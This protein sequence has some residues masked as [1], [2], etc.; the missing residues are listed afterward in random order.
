MFK[1]YVYKNVNNRPVN[2]GG[3]QF[4]EGQELESDILI[5]GFNEAVTNGFLELAERKP[6]GA[7]PDATQASQTGDTGKVKVIWHMLFAIDG[8]EVLREAEVDPG[9]LVY[10][11]GN[12]LSDGK[13][14]KGWFKDAELTK[15]VNIDKV[16]APKEGEIHLWQIRGYRKRRNPSWKSESE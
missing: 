11:P 12:E 9:V 6:E 14:T 8:T 2:I 7:E 15:P 3:Y 10:F 13:N 16:K 4:E 5:N 1:R